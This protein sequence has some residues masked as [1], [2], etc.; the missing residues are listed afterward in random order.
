LGNIKDISFDEAVKR[1]REYMKMLF[2]TISGSCPARDPK[3]KE[4]LRKILDREI[5]FSK[6][7]ECQN[8]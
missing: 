1:Q 3:G 5:V 7:L 6:Q 8:E 4:F 2:K